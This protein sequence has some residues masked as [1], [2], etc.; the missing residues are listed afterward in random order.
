MTEQLYVIYDRSESIF[1]QESIIFD[2]KVV[3]LGWE[4]LRFCSVFTL[5]RIEQLISDNNHDK[6]SQDFMID[7]LND[8][9]VFLIPVRV[10]NDG[11]L[12]E[13]KMDE[14]KSYQEII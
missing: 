9:D 12:K 7:A 13:M 2:Y 3:D 4:P 6:L 10:G 14:M 1:L 8:N 11:L 5:D